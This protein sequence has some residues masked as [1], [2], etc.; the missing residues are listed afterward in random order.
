MTDTS[1]DYTFF[2]T[3]NVDWDS[4][5][6]EEEEV[7]SNRRTQPIF[8]NKQD[9]EKWKESQIKRHK[10]EVNLKIEPD[11]VELLTQAKEQIKN[12]LYVFYGEENCDFVDMDIKNPGEIISFVTIE[13]MIKF[14]D[15][16]IFNKY[17][18]SHLIQG[19]Y[20]KYLFSLVYNSRY[21]KITMKNFTIRGY[22]DKI[23]KQEERYGYVHSHIEGPAGN[24]CFGGGLIIEY[25]ADLNTLNFDIER[26][27][28]LL[29]VIESALEF[30]DLDGGPHKRIDTLRTIGTN[31]G[32]TYDQNPQRV[33]NLSA[34][35]QNFGRLTDFF[36][37]HTIPP[38]SISSQGTIEVD[39]VKL[40]EYYK[41]ISDVLTSIYNKPEEQ[42]NTVETDIL[43]SLYA[44]LYQKINGTYQSLQG[45]SETNYTFPSF[46]FKK[47]TIQTKVI[48]NDNTSETELKVYIP[49]TLL[50]EVWEYFTQYSEPFFLKKELNKD[51]DE[52]NS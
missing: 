9:L 4:C 13:F 5:I 17:N 36:F 16:E 39:P 1:D 28:T 52:S 46:L 18:K 19:L 25:L 7:Q 50:K 47:Q 42:M 15:F 40:N 27:E 51:R 22:R 49:K 32:H 26:F 11:G 37:R 10:R 24:Y 43:G 3:S 23:T 29:T 44:F 45:N 12:S 34:A 6:I 41:S 21:N 48:N 14:P 31:I 2:D 35:I 30:E 8:R 33:I 20:L 38:L